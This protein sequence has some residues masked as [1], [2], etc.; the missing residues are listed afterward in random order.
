MPSRS[1]YRAT[2]VKEE[3][4]TVNKEE[5]IS[6]YNQ[7]RNTEQTAKKFKCHRR[8]VQKVLKKMGAKTVPQFGGHTGEVIKEEKFT[9]PYGDNVFRY[10]LTSAQNNTNVWDKWWD[11]LLALREHYDAILLVSPF[12]YNEQEY[13]DKRPGADISDARVPELYDPKVV[14][15]LHAHRA[16]LAPGLVFCGEMNILPTAV[17]PLSDLKTYTGHRSRIIPHVK[18]AMESLPTY[19]EPMA[20]FNYTTGTVTKQNYIQKKAGQKAAFHHTYGALLVEVN[21]AGEWWVRQLIA[22]RNGTVCD[23]DIMVKDGVVTKGNRVEAI[24][25]GDIHVDEIDQ[26]VHDMNWGPKGILDQLRPKYQFM[27]DTMSMYARNHHDQDDHHQM[28]QK[29]VDGRDS[30]EKELKDVVKFLSETSY[31]PWC[32]TVVVDSNHDLMLTKWLKWANHKTDHVNAIIYLELELAKR[33]AILAHD[34]SFHLVEYACRTL[35]VRKE[36][37]FLKPDESFLICKDIEAAMHGHDGPNGARGNPRSLAQVARRA[38]IGHTHS[39]AIIDG[40]YVAGTSTPRKLPYTH[41]PSSWSQSDIVTY[42]TGK[43]TIITK[44]N[45]KYKA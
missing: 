45:G 32:Q 6:Y 19:G 17:R 9:L 1:K 16:E 11:N 41:G 37:R 39:A 44:V 26:T 29:Y 33:K 2:E 18:V 3:G 14:P 8:T 34:K 36:I 24:N 5:L 4:M 25:W 30:V 20:K 40:L 38:N 42:S 27:H 28:Y 13:R 12:L 22:D 43:R 21:S 23:L 15:Y 31:R 7:C 10:I 35:G